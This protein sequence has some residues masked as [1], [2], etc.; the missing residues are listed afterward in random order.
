MRRNKLLWSAA[1]FFDGLRQLA[2]GRRDTA[3][4]LLDA[5]EQ[6]FD[7]ADYCYAARVI[8]GRIQRDPTWPATVPIGPPRSAGG[9]SDEGK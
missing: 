8:L 2:D 4:T 9:V 7:Y 3:Y 5:C 1:Y 6:T